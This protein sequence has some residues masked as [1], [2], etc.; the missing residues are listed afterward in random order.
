MSLSNGG[1]LVNLLVGNAITGILCYCLSL[2]GLPPEFGYLIWVVLF[3]LL[4]V[5]PSAVKSLSSKCCR[6]MGRA[7]KF[8]VK[9][10]KAGQED[11]NA[12]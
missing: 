7:W 3:L 1:F 10:F 5:L 4:F 6:L 2:L 12:A 8:V 11:D 9:E